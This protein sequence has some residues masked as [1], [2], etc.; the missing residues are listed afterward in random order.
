MEPVALAR[1]LLVI[2]KAFCYNVSAADCL[3]HAASGASCLAG[4]HLF[5]LVENSKDMVARLRVG[6]CAW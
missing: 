2:V 3:E 6:E 4:Q 5:T 1:L